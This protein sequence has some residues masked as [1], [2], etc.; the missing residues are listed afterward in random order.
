[1]EKAEQNTRGN[2]H[3]VSADFSWRDLFRAYWFLLDST[4]WRWL[5]LVLLL[6]IVQFYILVPPLI[7]GKIVDF[8]AIYH[9][10]DA[11]GRFYLY[12][13][14]LGISFAIVA[15]VRLSIKRAIGNLQSEVIYQTKVRGFAHL[16]DFS[17][18]WHLAESAGTKAQRVKN[19]VESYKVLNHNLS[20][21]VMRSIVSIIGMIGVFLFLR[22]QYAVFF[23]IYFIG[24][25]ALLTF[26]YRRIHDENNV[27]FSSTEKAS[28][29]YVEGLSNILTIK[30]LGAGQDFKGHVARKEQ[31]TKEH[32]YVIRTL[33]INL[34]KSFHIFNGVCFGVFLFMVG[35][36]VIAQNISPGSFVIF[37]GYLQSL[38]TTS[39]D[40]MD[41][42]EKLIS[43]KAGVGRMMGIFW[44]KTTAV[45]GTKTLPLD[46]N[47]IDVKDASFVYENSHVVVSRDDSGERPTNTLQNISLVVPRYAK[48]GV[49]GK[50]GSGKS[51]LAKLLAG[52]YPL[53]SGKYML[54]ATSFYDLKH[55]EQTKHVTLVLQET[56]VFNMSIRDNIT[57]LREMDPGL[58]EKALAIAQLD[59]VIAKLPE[60]LDTLVGEKG[61]HLSGGERQRVGIARAICRDS[62]IMIFDEATSSLDSKTEFLIQEALE[63]QLT[64]KTLVIIAHRVSTLQKTDRV[65]VF[66]QGKIVEQG[67]F[68]EL[69]ENTSSKF[70]ELYNIQQKENH[71]EKT[72]DKE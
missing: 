65:Y 57:L 13:G 41:V 11:I 17:L 12:I 43:S 68:S 64:E 20:N 5:S 48:I 18:S 66:D 63:T 27:Y 10:G 55:E 30:T 8:F 60:G 46:W 16:L 39:A 26:F 21:E 70:F 42:Y 59:D 23:C 6:F 37:Y 47:Q 36:D 34:W 2:A 19:G 24:F 71:T 33:S 58:L 67:K 9:I 1:M 40:M 15:F 31:R 52:L 35:R 38:V 51:T 53:V 62:S 61:Y 7:L 14:I 29:S 54:G 3:G 44:T 25:W 56:E 22:P 69:T 50:T 4:R 72:I 49:V 28:G 32:E 45:A